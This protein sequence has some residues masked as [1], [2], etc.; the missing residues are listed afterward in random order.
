M[1]EKIGQGLKYP[2]LKRDV[3]RKLPEY[4][5]WE[6]KDSF[7]TWDIAMFSTKDPSK[8][9]KM[10]LIKTKQPVNG[11]PTPYI[12]VLMLLSKPRKQGL[13]TKMLDY[14]QNFSKRNGCEGRFY[15]S[16]DPQ[17]TPKE[18]PH[19]FYRKYGM[20]T[21]YPEEDKKIDT[22]IKEGKNATIKEL[23]HIKMYY[24]P[25]QPLETPKPEQ[26]KKSLWQTLKGLF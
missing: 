4:L 1:I 25:I 18:A 17:F 13:G 22:F 20:N 23:S 14:V 10:S 16:A 7:D 15:L 8:T 11:R 26:P 12:L 21:G 5:F 3:N 6:H 19:I 2:P 9:G 24:P